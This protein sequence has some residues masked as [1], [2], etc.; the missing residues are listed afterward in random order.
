MFCMIFVMCCKTGFYSALKASG[1]LARGVTYNPYGPPALG[2]LFCCCCLCVCFALD[3]YVSV[4]VFSATLPPS[5]STVVR[6]L[7][8]MCN[9]RLSPWHI[10]FSRLWTDSFLW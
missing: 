3:K 8:G 1:S 7:T 10:F 4:T 6:E 9:Y 5:K 2:G